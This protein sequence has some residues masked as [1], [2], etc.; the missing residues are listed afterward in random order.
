MSTIYSIAFL[1]FQ[2]E[3]QTKTVLRQSLERYYTVQDKPDAVTL[4][5]NFIMA[6]VTRYHGTL[7]ARITQPLSFFQFQCCGVDNY[8]DF[9]RSKPFQASK[10]SAYQM[11]PA[12]CCILDTAKYPPFFQAVDSNCLTTPTSYNSY[13]LKV[14]SRTRARC[15]TTPPT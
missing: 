11:L 14:R 8:T 4:T 6:E 5:W 15:D 13:F 3:L 1:P 10:T 12:A 9:G 2:V 7:T